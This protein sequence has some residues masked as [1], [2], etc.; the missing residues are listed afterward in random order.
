M[1]DGRG[2]GREDEGEG[3]EREEEREHRGARCGRDDVSAVGQRWG[4]GSEELGGMLE[5][6]SRR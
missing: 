4:L 1:L 3:E 6:G 5:S 2:E